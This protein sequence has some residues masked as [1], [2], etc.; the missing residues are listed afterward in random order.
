MAAPFIRMRELKD[1]VRVRSLNDLAWFVKESEDIN[2]LAGREF[3][4]AGADRPA[5]RVSLD[6]SG[7]T[8]LRLDRDACPRVALRATA[9]ELGDHTVGDALAC[10][11]LYTAALQ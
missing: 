11:L 1:L 2:G 8:I 9:R 3:V 10:G 7:Y 5:F 4:V 6:Q